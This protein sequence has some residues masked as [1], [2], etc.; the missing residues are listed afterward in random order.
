MLLNYYADGDDYISQHKDNDSN[1]NEAFLTAV[2]SFGEKRT[3]T[4]KKPRCESTE[5][6]LHHGHVTFIYISKR[7][8]EDAINL[9]LI[10]TEEGRHY[11]LNK[12]FSRFIGDC[13]KHKEAQ[14]ICFRCFHSFSRKD[15]LKDHVSY[16]Q[17]HTAQK[18]ELPAPGRNMLQ[19]TSI[20]MQHP[21]AYAIYADFKSVLMPLDTVTPRQTLS[22]TEKTARH[23]PSGYA[24]IV[25]GPDGEPTEAI[26]T[27]HG[28]DCVDKFIIS[29]LK[30]KEKL[31]SIL[32]HIMP[33]KLTPLEEKLFREARVCCICKKLLGEFRIRDH[34]HLSGAYRGAA[35][36]ACNLIL[37]SLRS[38]LCCSIT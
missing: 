19:F 27:Y 38:S 15:L 29:V 5:M 12:D 20:H 34:D 25:I 16:C 4:F 35:H 37:S 36:K 2:L 30:E 23:V 11:A 14:H 26:K 1:M 22:F 7:E 28:E 9:L 3:F 6:D 10:A 18:I 17:N 33:M 31:S 21:I 24:Y 8:E 13:T 32:T